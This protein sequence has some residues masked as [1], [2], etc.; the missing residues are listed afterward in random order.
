M[1]K[2]LFHASLSPFHIWPPFSKTRKPHQF[3]LEKPIGFELRKTHR[4]LK[5]KIHA[6][7]NGGVLENFFCLPSQG[8]FFIVPKGKLSSCTELSKANF[9][10]VYNRKS[11]P[12]PPKGK[13]F[14]SENQKKRSKRLFPP[15]R[16][17]IFEGRRAGVGKVCGE[18]VN[19][20]PASV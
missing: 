1:F 6:R 14:P 16:F 4:F 20:N 10:P 15:Q 3:W 8:R 17:E 18:G 13:C 12:L 19:H 7:P 11:P 9:L 2:N 5:K